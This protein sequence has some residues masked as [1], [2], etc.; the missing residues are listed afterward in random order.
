MA[1]IT[2]PASLTLMS[3]PDLNVDDEKMR[4]Q[5]LWAANHARAQRQLARLRAEGHAL[6]ALIAQ[7]LQ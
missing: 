4:L 1:A 3:I 5:K 2:S 6:K 7:A